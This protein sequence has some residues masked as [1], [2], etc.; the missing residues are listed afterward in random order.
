M[1]PDTY[2]VSVTKEGYNPTTFPGITVFADQSQTVTVKLQKGLKTIANVSARAAGNLVKSG[3]TAD[4]YSVN[5]ATQ[6]TV[7]GIG[8]GGNLDSAYS[9][10]YSQPGVVSQIGNYG[11][12]QVYY[13]R[14]SSYSQVGYEYD[15]VPVNRAFDNYNANSLSSLG[16]QET[17]IYTGGSPAGGTSAT[18]AGY[19]NQVIKTGTFPGY[20]QGTLGIGTPAF[21]HKAGVEAGGATPDRLF[22]WYV[23]I[24]GSNQMYNTLD[25]TNGANQPIDGSGPNG[26]FSSVFNAYA[27]TLSFFPNGTFST[28]SP[29]GAPSGALGYDPTFNLLGKEFK[30]HFPTQPSCNMYTP[31]SGS[32]FLGLPVNTQDRENVANFHFGIPHHN[33]A[34]KDDVQLLYY[35]FAY[36]QY[37]GDSVSDQGG[38]G[39]INQGFPGWQSI[40]NDFGLTTYPGSNGPYANLCGYEAVF[41]VGCATTGSSTLPYIDK[42]Q[43]GPGTTFGQSSSTA[44]VINYSAPSQPPHAFNGGVPVDGRDTTWNDGSV[45]KL[46]YQK[47]FGST[48]YVRLMGYSFYSNWLMSS[49]NAGNEAI[50]ALWIQRRRFRLSVAGLRTQHAHPRPPTDGGRS[51]QRAKPR[52]IDRQLYDGQ[53]RALEQP[54]VRGARQPTNFVGREGNCYRS[55]LERRLTVCCRGR[56]ARTEHRGRLDDSSQNFHPYPTSNPCTA[57]NG[58]TA[59]AGS[60]ACNAGAT[61]IVTV[62]DGYGTINNVT[63]QFRR[64]RCKTSFVRPTVGTQPRRPLRE[65]RL[66]APTDGEPRDELLVHPGPE[67]LLLRPRNRT[68]DSAPHLAGNAAGKCGAA[69]PAECA[70]QRRN[71]RPLLLL[72]GPSVHLAVGTASSPSQRPRRKRPVH[73]REP[74]GFLAPALVAAYRRHLYVRSRRRAAVQLRPLHATDG[75]GVRAV[76][77]RIGLG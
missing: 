63:P 1:S 26:I 19:I 11:F 61:T 64:S 37:F 22:S 75:N 56:A 39:Y 49:P 27:S 30:Q 42:H 29:T 43:F 2:T 31:W 54:V 7:Q 18:L 24:Q 48:A 71:A 25:D 17:E 13:I 12:G 73:R 47:N 76:R 68:A 36:H 10:I 70:G 65:L 46:Q 41:F 9:A 40:A 3:T 66:P 21:Y 6:A 4:V 67:R 15:G 50:T 32:G 60:A 69:D 23:G 16:S 77:K 45:I 33:D 38:E 52:A 44:N 28:C 5:A 35:N 58:N 8:G 34:G 74:F 57:P 20:A 53:R 59:L 72:A 14:G 55:R 62:P 51:D